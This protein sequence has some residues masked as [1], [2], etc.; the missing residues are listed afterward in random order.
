MCFLCSLVPCTVLLVLAFVVFIAASTAAGTARSMGRIL[1]A[2]VIIV[3][4]FFP[5]C[6]AYVTLARLCPMGRV[7][8]R[9]QEL[10][11]RQPG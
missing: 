6:G 11:L 5:I 3:A 9:M 8:E 4:V 2:W 1:T 10:T 7:M